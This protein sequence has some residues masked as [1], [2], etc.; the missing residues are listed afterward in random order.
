MI[1]RGKDQ[2]RLPRL[3]V[4]EGGGGLELALQS[5]R[6]GSLRGGQAGCARQ[7]QEQTGFR[8]GSSCV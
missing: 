4:P 2:R 6:E 7:R 3:D 5:G 1:G 8:M